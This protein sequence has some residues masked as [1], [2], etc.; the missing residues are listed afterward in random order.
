VAE[1]HVV[2]IRSRGNMQVVL[3]AKQEPR[4]L[5]ARETG[6]RRPTFYGVHTAVL[7]VADIA[8]REIDRIDDG[9]GVNLR[10]AARTPTEDAQRY[11]QGV[12]AR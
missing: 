3:S 2:D 9:I 1:R 4:G 10:G 11:E 7:R 5:E 12:S 8:A 6:G